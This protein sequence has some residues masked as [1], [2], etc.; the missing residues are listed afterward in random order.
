MRNFCNEPRPVRANGDGADCVQLLHER[1]QSSRP[2]VGRQIQ[3]R[4]TLGHELH[5]LSDLSKEIVPNAS[6]FLSEAN[7]SSF[8]SEAEALHI[9]KLLFA[10][11][12]KGNVLWPHCPKDSINT[13]QRAT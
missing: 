5:K 12:N 7:A 11:P 8:L 1:S 10:E 9:E 4:P 2:N 3:R 13:A 6:S